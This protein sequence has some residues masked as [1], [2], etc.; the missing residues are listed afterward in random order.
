M[1]GLWRVE[2]WSY[3]GAKVS[4][5]YAFRHKRVID[6]VANNSTNGHGSIVYFFNK[7]KELYGP[8]GKFGIIQ[9]DKG[10]V[11]RL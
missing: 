4:A 5:K 10:V 1:I 11:I 7:E 3:W 9:I 8:L 6:I 2:E